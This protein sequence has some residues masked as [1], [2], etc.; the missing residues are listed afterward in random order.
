MEALATYM[1]KLVMLLSFQSHGNLGLLMKQLANGKH[2]LLTQLMESPTHGTKKQLL[3]F[4][5]LK[6]NISI[7]KEKAR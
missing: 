7:Q 6:Y 1:T 5:F 3:G 4:C 2:L